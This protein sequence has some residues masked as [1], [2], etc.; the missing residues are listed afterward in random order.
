[1]REKGVFLAHSAQLLC[2]LARAAG[3]PVD[4][5]PWLRLIPE[6]WSRY[7]HTHAHTHTHTMPQAL[8]TPL[9][10][11]RNKRRATHAGQKRLLGMMPT[12]VSV[13]VPSARSVCY[14]N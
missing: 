10:M 6:G 12:N 8:A 2:C 13:K 5:G 9:K 3:S 14:W 1:M 4:I 7:A 11:I